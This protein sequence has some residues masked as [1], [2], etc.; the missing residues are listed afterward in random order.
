[1]IWPV[2]DKLTLQI[3]LREVFILFDHKEDDLVKSQQKYQAKAKEYINDP[4]KTESLLKKALHKAT[5]RKD[6]PRETWGK[7]KLLVELTK[8]YSSGEYRNVSKGTILTLLGTILY[9]V[10]PMD[11]VPDFIIGLGLVDDAAV[12]GYALK[13][14][15]GEVEHYK[16]WKLH[17]QKDPLD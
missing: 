17:Q 11:V 12:I 4:V 3:L 2:C 1:M 16:N 8:A 14:I 9:F 6:T 5:K 15:S 13:R 10:S 7:L